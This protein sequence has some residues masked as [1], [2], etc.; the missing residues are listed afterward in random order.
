MHTKLQHARMPPVTNDVCYAKNRKR[1]PYNKVTPGMV[2]AGEGG[3]NPISGCHGDS[4]GPYACEV[5]GQ[6]ELHGAVSWGSSRC[7][8][9]ES[10]TVFARVNYFKTWIN[11]QIQAN[12]M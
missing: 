5:N 1:L 7:S 12:G 2:C 3:I 4:G 6:F 9:K 11:T 8:S 10:Y